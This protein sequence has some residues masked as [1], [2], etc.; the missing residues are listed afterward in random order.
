MSQHTPDRPPE[1]ALEWA[2][3]AAYLADA[4]KATD[5][6]I[7]RTEKVTQLADYFV[8]CSGQSKTQVRAIAEDIA[9][10]FKHADN[11]PSSDERDVN[12]TW[13]LLDFRDIVVHVMDQETRGFY[14]LE[15]FWSHADLIPAE[16]WYAVAT[17]LGL[18]NLEA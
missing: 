11:A 18:I 5:I 9:Y 17:E 12:S 7:L 2:A 1:T 16:E 13:C 15:Q 8:I 3:W 6:Q 4:K 10:E 14:Q